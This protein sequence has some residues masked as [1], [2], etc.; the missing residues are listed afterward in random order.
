MLSSD[1]VQWKDYL[2]EGTFKS[3]ESIVKAE[4]TQKVGWEYLYSAPPNLHKNTVTA[5]EMNALFVRGE[6]AVTVLRTP[7]DHKVRVRVRSRT[8]TLFSKLF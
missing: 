2:V 7:Y 5:S 8:P 1:G 6:Q 4:L 3:I